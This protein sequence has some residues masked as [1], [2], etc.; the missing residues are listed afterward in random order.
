MLPE[1]KFSLTNKHNTWPSLLRMAIPIEIFTAVIL[2][3]IFAVDDRQMTRIDES[4][5]EVS[6]RL[7]LSRDS[8]LDLKVALDDAVGCLVDVR[9]RWLFFTTIT[10]N[11]FCDVVV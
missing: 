1:V 9:C 6:Y 10:L 3:E 11:H 4:E 5:D 2:V 7:G 8:R